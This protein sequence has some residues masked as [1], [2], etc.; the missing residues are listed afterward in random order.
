MIII[1]MV[2]H[3]FTHISFTLWYFNSSLLNMA[4]IEIVDLPNLKMAIFNGY[5]SL[6]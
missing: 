2:F 3:T 6:P 5:V 1:S 4:L